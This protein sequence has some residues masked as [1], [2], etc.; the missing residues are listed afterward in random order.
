MKIYDARE[1]K[2]LNSNYL[3][4]FSKAFVIGVEIVNEQNK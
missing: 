3:L 4:V 2:M 1:F